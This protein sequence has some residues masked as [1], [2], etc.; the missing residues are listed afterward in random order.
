M[1]WECLTE[2][3]WG[4]WQDNWLVEWCLAGHIYYT[5]DDD[6]EMLKSEGRL[7]KTGTQINKIKK[8][9]NEYRSNIKKH[10]ERTDPCN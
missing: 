6:V 9:K 3:G 1:I 10:K 7:Q 8:K 4:E 5:H 2:P